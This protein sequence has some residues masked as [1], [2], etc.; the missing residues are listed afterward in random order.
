MGSGAGHRHGGWEGR[1]HPFHFPM[2]SLPAFRIS[3]PPQTLEELGVSLQLMDTL[4]HDL[5]N[6]ENQIP[7]IHEQFAILEKYEVPVPDPVSPS[8]VWST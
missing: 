2:L 3:H 6:L 7:P 5:P 4:Q 1:P 8:G